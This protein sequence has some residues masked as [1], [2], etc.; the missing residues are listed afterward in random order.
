MKVKKLTQ[1]GL[2]TAVA[3]IIF[4]VELR[5][6][7]LVP[8][9]GVKLGLANIVTV[10][11]LYKYKP[12]EAGLVLIARILLGSMFSGN[13]SSLLYSVSGALLC[14]IGMTILCKLVPERFMWLSSIFGAIFHNIGQMVAAVV[15]MG[16]FSVIAYLPFLMIS[17]CIA[18]LFTGVCAQ[19]LVF[20][21][22]KK[23]NNK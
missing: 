11:A 19:L 10:Y 15:L 12:S 8:I 22:E 14:F 2:L 3:L 7:N 6:P 1:L 9:P 20:R 23:K 4:I 21:I 5:I 17:G 18:G 13:M 16:T